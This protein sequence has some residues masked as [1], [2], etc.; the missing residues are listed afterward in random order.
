MPSAQRPAA[1]LLGLLGLLGV[2]GVLISGQ[3][4]GLALLTTGVGLLLCAVLVVSASAGAAATGSTTTHAVRSTALR[5]RAWRTAFLPQRDP[6]ARGR[7]RPRAPG[8]GP[9]AA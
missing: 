8:T 5:R 2:P 3:P 6:D 1:L 9:A 7:C 4:T